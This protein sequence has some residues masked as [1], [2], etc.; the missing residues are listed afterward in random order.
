MRKADKKLRKNIGKTTLSE[1]ES[2]SISMTGFP[3]P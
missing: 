1:E 2:G 3:I